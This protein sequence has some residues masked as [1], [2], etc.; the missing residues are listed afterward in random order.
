MKIL[1][2]TDI[3]SDIDDALAMLL[4]LRLSEIEI[5][6]VTTVY[7]D[8]GTRAKVAK[9]ILDAAGRTVPVLQG[10]SQPLGSIMPIWHTGTE[11]H[12]ILTEEEMEAPVEDFGIGTGADDFIMEAIRANPHEVTIVSL[13][14][15]TNIAKAV[16]RDDC[17][18]EKTRALFFMGGGVTYPERVPT[19]I[20]QGPAYRAYPSHNARCDVKAAQIVFGSAIPMWVLTNDVTTTLWWDG[21]PVQRLMQATWPREAAVVGKLLTV[22]LDYRTMV[23]GKRITGTCPHDPLTVAEVADRRFV[24]YEPGKMEIQDDG[25]TLFVPDSKGRHRAGVRVDSQGFISW[26]S[27]HLM[28]S[29]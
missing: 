25:S 11:G 26:L 24:H 6:G 29:P 27:G 1:L 9:R 18:C 5:V 8:V 10:A 15:L 20:E 3:G 12:G 4:L 17:L 23:F 2:D 22:W 7:G 14:A 13:G 28:G 21:E 19:N 16:Q